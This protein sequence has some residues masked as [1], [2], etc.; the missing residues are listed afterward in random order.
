MSPYGKSIIRR[1]YFLKC[2]IVWDFIPR[3]P[4]RLKEYST[5]HTVTKLHCSSRTSFGTRFNIGCEK[6]VRSIILFAGWVTLLFAFGFFSLDFLGAIFSGISAWEKYS[7]IREQKDTDNLEVVCTYNVLSDFYFSLHGKWTRT[8]FDCIVSLTPSSSFSFL[9]FFKNAF[10]EKLIQNEAK[11]ETREV[12]PPIKPR[13]T[14]ATVAGHTPTLMP[15]VHS[16]TSYT[17]K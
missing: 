10:S 1:V 8:S 13:T 6:M 7:K 14:L 12:T 3:Q 16:E 11:T 17:L 4:K 2:R 5:Q 15:Y 9:Y